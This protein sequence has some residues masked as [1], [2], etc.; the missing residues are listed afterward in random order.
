MYKKGLIFIVSGL[1]LFVFY[2]FIF[3]FYDETVG[4]M[5]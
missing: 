1:V 3:L 5:P 4:Y 2:I